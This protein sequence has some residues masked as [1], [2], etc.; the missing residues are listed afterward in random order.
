MATKRSPNCPALTLPDAI[1]MAGKIRNKEGN[2]TFDDGVAVTHMGYGGL[3]GASRTV[4]GA[5]R[6]YGLLEGRSPNLS[7]SKDAVSIFVGAKATDPKDQKDRQE[8]LL[9]A[10][11]Y[12]NVFSDLHKKFKDGSTVLNISSY[13]QKNHDFKP[14]AAEKIAKIYK[15]SAEF[16]YSE[17]KG[18]SGGSAG[19]GE[20][21]PPIIEV[22]DIIQWT[23]QGVDQLESPRKVR[24]IEESRE[25]LFVENSKTGIPMNEA[26]LVEKGKKDAFKKPP[27]MEFGES[28]S[29]LGLSNT[30]KEFSRGK[31]SSKVDYR[32]IMSGEVGAEEL[33]KLIKLLEAQKDV[34]S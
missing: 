22:G 9:R 11:T 31:L 21:A 30:E 4:L 16:V 25:W 32:L 8:A 15:D 23:S 18:Y 17:Y 2:S 34:L 6:G 29:D 27:I 12:N 28:D 20:E 26:T 5:V 19:T 24:A 13:L 3:N 7:I 1:P 14:Q 33:G 10:L